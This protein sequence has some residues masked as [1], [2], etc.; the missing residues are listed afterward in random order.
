LFEAGFTT[1][2]R[3]CLMWSLW[4]RDKAITLT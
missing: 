1:D 3:Y 4:N 2:S